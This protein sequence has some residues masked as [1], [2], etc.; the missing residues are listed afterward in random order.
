MKWI[1]F[2]KISQ[3]SL[4]ILL[5]LPSQYWHW[6]HT[7]LQISGTV[8][9]QFILTLYNIPFNLFILNHWVLLVLLRLYPH[10][11]IRRFSADTF[12]DTE[13]VSNTFQHTLID[14]NANISTTNFNSS[15]FFF[16]LTYL[17]SWDLG[18]LTRDMSI[19]III[20]WSSFFRSLN[21][22]RFWKGKEE[23]LIV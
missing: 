5:C 4:S 17:C 7:Y 14:L 2:F 18:A 9:K 1:I 15:I 22:S 10:F 3:P 23:I 11:S 20:E 8:P 12:W 16:F 21:T 19:I 13:R 6:K